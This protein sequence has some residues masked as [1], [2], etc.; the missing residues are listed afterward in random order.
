MTILDFAKRVGLLKIKDLLKAAP[1]ETT[2]ISQDD[3]GFYY[4]R[5][6]EQGLAIF[7]KPHQ[8]WWGL[9]RDASHKFNIYELKTIV[10]AFML[11]NAIGLTKESYLKI[12]YGNVWINGLKY[13]Q[14]R[15]LNAFDLVAGFEVMQ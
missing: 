7:N 3:D 9:G 13:T 12:P 14:P 11:V 10:E 5:E 8:E 6:N 1:F 2:H 4:I 15:I